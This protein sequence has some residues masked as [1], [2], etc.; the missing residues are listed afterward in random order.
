M[1]QQGISRPEDEVEWIFCR[2]PQMTS[3]S[4]WCGSACLLDEFCQQSEYQMN[5]N[6]WATIP[7][8]HLCVTKTAG[9]L[10]VGP[11]LKTVR[12]LKLG[13]FTQRKVSPKS[14]DQT[15]WFKESIWKSSEYSQLPL[16]RMASLFSN[17]YFLHLLNPVLHAKI[18]GLEGTDV[19]YALSSSPGLIHKHSLGFFVHFISPPC[20]LVYNES[21]TLQS[22]FKVLLFQIAWPIN[23]VSLSLQLSVECKVSS[24]MKQGKH[25]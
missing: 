13:Y 24:H 14:S 5:P 11:Q 1:F 3:P 22:C 8:N 4:V 2:N 6:P 9:E 7:E 23:K 10:V 16:D 21:S 12:H 20:F 15:G 17:F 19:I 25:V 18:S